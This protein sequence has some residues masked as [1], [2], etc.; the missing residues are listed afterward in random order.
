MKLELSCEGMTTTTTTT[1][2]DSEKYCTYCARKNPPMQ[3]ILV[4]GENINEYRWTRSRFWCNDCDREIQERYRQGHKKKFADYIQRLHDETIDELSDQWNDP[5]FKKIRELPERVIKVWEK[6][7][8]FEP[9]KGIRRDW[10]CEVL[11]SDYWFMDANTIVEKYFEEANIKK[12]LQASKKTTLMEFVMHHH[13]LLQ[14]VYREKARNRWSGIV[15]A[16][17]NKHGSKYK[18]VASPFH[19]DEAVKEYVR[20]WFLMTRREDKEV[21]DDKREERRLRLEEIDDEEETIVQYWEEVRRK[22]EQKQTQNGQSEQQNSGG[23][24]SGQ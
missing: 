10:I 20:N 9:G 22:E 11:F 18:M 3:T 4:R 14:E 7:K 1:P 12:S 5:A 2:T 24:N 21:R 17:Y 19:F 6:A 8:R 16:I 23:E 13:E 15:D